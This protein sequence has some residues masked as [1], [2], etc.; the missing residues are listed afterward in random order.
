MYAQLWSQC[1]LAKQIP[2]QEMVSNLWV[3]YMQDRNKQIRADLLHLS[4]GQLK[5]LIWIALGHT[6]GITSKIAQQNIGITSATISHSLKIL[7]EQDYIEKLEN[8]T[9]RIIDP[10]IKT[11]LTM[12]YPKFGS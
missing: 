5:I 1:K 7:E 10:I 4:Q 6:T 12:H 2:T 3:A 11:S 9:Y 8:N